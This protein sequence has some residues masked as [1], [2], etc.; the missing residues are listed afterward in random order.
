MKKASKILEP[1][2]TPFDSNIKFFER[3]CTDEQ[4]LL[5]IPNDRTYFE[6]LGHKF[7]TGKKLKTMDDIANWLKHIKEVEEEN[8]QIKKQ[9]AEFGEYVRVK[10]EEAK[11]DA[12][13]IDGTRI[14]N[15]Q[16]R[17]YEDIFNRMELN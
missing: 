2:T 5:Y 1:I 11:L 7:E 16:E 10:Y 14:P 4:P 9:M 15:V 6:I 17:I 12:Q 8:E 3:E 13:Y